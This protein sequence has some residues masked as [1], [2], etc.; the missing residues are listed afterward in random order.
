MQISR[1]LNDSINDL[2]CDDVFDD[3][4]DSDIQLL[5]EAIERV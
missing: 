5:I 3:Y 1:F 2:L 4:S